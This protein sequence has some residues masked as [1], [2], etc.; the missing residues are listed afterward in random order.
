VDQPYSATDLFRQ[1][2]DE[3]RVEP[4]PVPEHDRQ[5]PKTKVPSHFF[6]AHHTHP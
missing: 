1:A 4:G 3:T 6:I 2:D 5:V